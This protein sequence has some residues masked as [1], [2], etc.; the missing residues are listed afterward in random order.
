MLL[1]ALPMSFLVEFAASLLRGEAKFAS[2]N[3]IAD[4]LVTEL[5]LREGFDTVI[6]DAQHGHHTEATML[7]SISAAASVGKPA[8]ARIAVGD[9]AGAAKMLDGGAAGI[10]AP[11]IN[12]AADA[13]AFGSYLK[14]P[15]LGERSWGPNRGIGFSG[16]PMVEY[17]HQAN[18][19][20]LAIAMIETRAALADLDAILAEPTIDGV[21]VGP[22]DLSIA[23]TNGG[24]VDSLHPEVDAALTHVAA[25]CQA[26]GKLATCFAMTGARAAE[27]VSRGY[28]LVSVSTDQVLLRTAARTELAA[29]KKAVPSGA[30]T[31]S[32]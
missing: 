4:A 10:I 5:A 17:L 32:Y 26:H 13:R 3:G 27:M 23:L 2:F 1:D 25:R 6:L 7:A 30:A 31:R 24:T 18:G 9:F 21:F 22:S 14:Y 12:S 8:L 20:T 16:L 29:A 15:P 11:M 28:A 19:F